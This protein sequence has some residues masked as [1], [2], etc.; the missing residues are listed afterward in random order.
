MAASVGDV[1]SVFTLSDPHQQLVQ[2]GN[3]AGVVRDSGILALI[4]VII[5]VAA[6]FLVLLV[7][8]AGNQ[9]DINRSE[10]LSSDSDKFVPQYR[11][12]MS[13][14]GRYGMRKSEPEPP[15]YLDPSLREQSREQPPVA[16]VHSESPVTSPYAPHVQPPHPPQ[17]HHSITT[18]SHA[19]PE[20]GAG[21]Y[22]RPHLEPLKPPDASST[23]SNFSSKNL[24]PGLVIPEGHSCVLTLPTL[25]TL[26]VPPRNTA[27]FFARDLKGRPVIQ[28]EILYQPWNS[29]G[30]TLGQRPIAVLRTAISQGDEPATIS[31]LSPLLAYV[32]ASIEAG[33][34]RAAYIYDACDDIFAH[35]A[36]DPFRQCYALTSSRAKMQILFAGNFGD[37]Q[38]QVGNDSG[39]SLAE[40]EPCTVIFDTAGEYYKIRAVSHVD[41]GLMICGLLA[42][43]HMEA[44]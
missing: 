14:K 26:N 17:A 39:A 11:S 9:L 35:I 1:S 43:E 38:V 40:V 23:G 7:G 13:T 6:L 31:D 5:V 4:L 8:F 18:E 29:M 15:R 44:E 36:K 30:V 16:R 32:K 28:A 34:R 37:H 19:P 10:E 42:I 25:R 12:R 2:I 3:S 24:C 21:S 22:K 20:S 27:A 41:V 33:G